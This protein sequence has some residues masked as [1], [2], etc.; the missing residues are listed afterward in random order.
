M[1][2]KWLAVV[3]GLLLIGLQWRVRNQREDAF[4]LAERVAEARRASEECTRS[5]SMA[6]SAFGTLNVQ[7]DSL[8]A[9]VQGYEALDPDGVPAAQYEEYLGAVDRYN[10]AVT[11]WESTA[12]ALRTTETTCRATIE[13]HNSLADSVRAS[14]APDS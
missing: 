4:R 9:R 6:Q 13:R 3:V 8:R 1:R 10:D 5:L 2:L 14:L 7:V 11:R 12:D